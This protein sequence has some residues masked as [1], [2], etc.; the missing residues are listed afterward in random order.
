M[1]YPLRVVSKEQFG[2]A[3]K[4][5]F[6]VVADLLIVFLLIGKDERCMTE[7]RL[8]FKKSIFHSIIF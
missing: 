3:G 4:E 1:E 8:Y 5:F 2:D 6:G 7:L